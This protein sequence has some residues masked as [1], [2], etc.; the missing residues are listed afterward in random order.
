MSFSLFLFKIFF[1]LHHLH[2]I[3]VFHILVL[4]TDCGECHPEAEV[5]LT[6]VL[7]V[8]QSGNQGDGRDQGNGLLQYG[9]TI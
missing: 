4:S 9:K 5:V 7:V 8:A 1:K 6:V 2:K 3:S